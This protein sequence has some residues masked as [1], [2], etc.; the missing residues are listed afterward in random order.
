MIAGD[1]GKGDLYMSIR[2]LLVPVDGSDRAE[3]VL[4]AAL[5]VS[6]QLDAHLEALHVKPDAREAVPLL[7]EGMSGAM[8]EEMI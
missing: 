7:G 1:A 2:S 6:K 8:I 5:A 3:G 4:A